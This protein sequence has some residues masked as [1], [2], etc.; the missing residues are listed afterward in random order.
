MS[1]E[2]ARH[3]TLILEEDNAP[4]LSTMPCSLGHYDTSSGGNIGRSIN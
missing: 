1:Y 2:F 3:R 4:I